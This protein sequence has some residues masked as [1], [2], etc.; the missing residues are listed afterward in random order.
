MRLIELSILEEQP[1][2]GLSS[3]IGAEV[4]AKTPI[5]AAVGFIKKLEKVS[6]NWLK[7]TSIGA[8]KVY[9]GDDENSGVV[10]R[11]IVRP[12]RRPSDTPKHLHILANEI[13]KETGL[14]ANRSNSIFVTGS[15]YEASNYGGKLWI[16]I[17]IGDFSYTW[18]PK[19]KDLTLDV[20]KEIETK[21][22][23]LQETLYSA[24][25]KKQKANYIAQNDALKEKIREIKSL[26]NTEADKPKSQTVFQKED[27][28]IEKLDKAIHKLRKDYNLRKETIFTSF[29]TNNL[30]PAHYL[31]RDEIEEIKNT[32]APAKEYIKKMFFSKYQGDDGSLV[33]AINSKNEIML[34]SKD[35]QTPLTVFLIGLVFWESFVTPLLDGTSE[36]ELEQILIRQGRIFKD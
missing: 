7:Q 18:S 28:A 34:A 12:D 36:E 11:K 5:K 23:N 25:E 8:F 14:T 15:E 32:V 16:V 2:Y 9:R 27:E 1:Q 33:D 21:F 35:G 20:A 19:I 3:F 10:V 13:F 22:G 26:P 30:V 24:I 6:S 31:S 4:F 17:P 29:L